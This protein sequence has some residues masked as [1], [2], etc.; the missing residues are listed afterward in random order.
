M[1]NINDEP[2]EDSLDR[3]RPTPSEILQDEL[4]P[5]PTGNTLCPKIGAAQWTCT[6]EECTCHLK[7]SIP[8]RCKICGRP[9]R[10]KCEDGWLPPIG[11]CSDDSYITSR[12]CPNA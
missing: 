2:D 4:E 6:R 7:E 10:E 5:L 9:K 3:E 12:P 11:P 1:T 8:E